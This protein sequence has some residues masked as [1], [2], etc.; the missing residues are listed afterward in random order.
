MTI[1]NINISDDNKITLIIDGTTE[2]PL[3]APYCAIIKERMMLQELRYAITNILDDEIS[4]GYIDID[5]YDGTREEFEEEIYTNFESEILDGE[6]NSLCN[7]G[8]WIRERITDEANYY[9]LEP[10]DT[11]DDDDWEE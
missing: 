7:D 5:K 9:E 10:D 8:Q 2:L 1:T 11:E 6:Y 4:G 3:S